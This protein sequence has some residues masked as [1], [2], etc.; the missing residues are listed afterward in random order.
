MEDLVKDIKKNT[1]NYRM[2]N[3]QVKQLLKQ[4]EKV[5]PLRPREIFLWLIKTLKDYDAV[6]SQEVARKLEAEYKK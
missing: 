3:F 2:N 6:A 1:R 4:L 5:V